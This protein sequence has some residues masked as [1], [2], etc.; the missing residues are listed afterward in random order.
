MSTILL[1]DDE[2]DVLDVYSELLALMGHDVIRA[3]DGQQALELAWQHR[4]ELELVVTDCVM[5][6]MNGIELC[7]A[8]ARAP[9]FQ[10]LPII[11]HSSS[12]NPRAP[13]VQVFLPKSGRLEQFE[14]VVTR[15]LNATP[16]RRQAPCPPRGGPRAPPVMT[17][18]RRGSPTPVP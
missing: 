1:V 16:R 14:E 15:V 2:A 12:S 13:G 5:P 7:S 9:E 10:G 17:D 4:T 3:S 8:L 11:M 18:S 6:R